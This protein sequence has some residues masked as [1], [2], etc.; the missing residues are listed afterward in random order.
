MDAGRGGGASKIDSGNFSRLGNGG[1]AAAVEPV[2]GYAGYVLVRVRVQPRASRNA[3]VGQDD[4]G[5]RIALTA[6][7]VDGAANKAL[8]AF[9]A[10]QLRV[11]K[12]AVR[13][14]AGLK[15]R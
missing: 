14:S 4:R 12:S 6:P 7:P 5:L 9:L 2:E 11:S 15:S 8:E 1:K 13:V 3:L 10:E